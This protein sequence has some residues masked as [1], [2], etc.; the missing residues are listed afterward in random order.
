MNETELFDRYLSKEMSDEEDKFRCAVGAGQ[1][2][3][4]KLSIC[5]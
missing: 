4:A 5:M 1:K 3:C 2:H